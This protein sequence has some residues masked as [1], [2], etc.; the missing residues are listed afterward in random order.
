MALSNTPTAYG[1]LARAF[2]WLTA[3]LILTAIG[4]ALYSED[5]PRASDGDVARLATLFSLH[6]TLGIAAFFTALLRILWAMTQPQPGALH[7]NRRLET[8][9]AELVHWSLYAAMLVMPLSGWFYHAATAGFAPILWPFGQS[10]PF[11]PKSPALADMFRSIHGA[12]SKL[13]YLS[14]ALHVAGALKHAVVD[15]D[16]T[17]ARMITGVSLPTPPQN[18]SA[19]AIV[20]A[21][22]GWAA[23]IAIGIVTTP[24]QDPA[25]NIAITAKAPVGGNWAVAEGSLGF[26]VK[27]M[28]ADVSG[29][30]TGWSA[31]I[32][33]DEIAHSGAVTATI[34]LS[35]MTVG[36]VTPQAAGPEFF[37]I[38]TNPTATFKGDIAETNGQL[39]AIGTL[40]LRGVTMPVTLPFS[41]KIDGDT[42]TMTGQTT[43]DRRD[44]GMG[45][46]YPDE[47]TVGFAVTV[48]V[49]LT[50]K[51]R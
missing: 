51:R 9:A 37:D 20:L 38:S 39:A 44:F 12:S 41:L 10:L 31:E 47:T 34:P 29:S 2:H 1:S 4:I 6:K 7:P 5:L 43:L 8:F 11:V 35:G 19:R 48:D 18:P 13:L 50:A 36:S 3:L 14:I 16:G 42:A 25:K 22:A 17:L 28:T 27:Q 49:A 33:Y 26:T 23:I 32:T 30:F 21:L 15:R 24:A 45:P 46:S 40:S